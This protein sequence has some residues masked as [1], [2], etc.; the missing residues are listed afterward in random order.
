MI[1]EEEIL[2]NIREMGYLTVKPRVILP[3]FY[4]LAD[5]TIL[6]AGIRIESIAKDPTQPSGYQVRVGNYT[7]AYVPSQE[8]KPSEY[9]PFNPSEILTD[10]VND[11]VE[12]EE[13]KEEFSKYIFSTTMIHNRLF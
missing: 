7:I 10:I 8:R 13:L 2:G 1:P 12:A 9:R 4:K 6:E 5:G 11:D 3:S